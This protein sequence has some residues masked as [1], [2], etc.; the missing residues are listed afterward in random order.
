MEK[1]SGC[2]VPTAPPHPQPNSSK[3][4]GQG[5]FMERDPGLLPSW[6]T[7]AEMQHVVGQLQGERPPMSPQSVVIHSW[8]EG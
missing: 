8:P 3:P 2:F 6:P 7:L 4:W 5:C 1:R